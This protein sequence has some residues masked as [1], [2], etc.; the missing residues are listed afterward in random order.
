MPPNLQTYHDLG[1]IRERG[2]QSLKQAAE[3]RIK[4]LVSGIIK[5]FLLRYYK[6]N[7]STMM[8]Q[9]IT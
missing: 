5:R 8:H 2:L 3:D 4:I 6:I 1:F 7:R 9:H